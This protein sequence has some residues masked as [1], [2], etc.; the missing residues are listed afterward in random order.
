MKNKVILILILVVVVLVA[1]FGFMSIIELQEKYDD[2]IRTIS[3][4]VVAASWSDY[5]NTITLTDAHGGIFIFA[6]REARVYHLTL[7]SDYNVTYSVF[8]SPPMLK[9]MKLI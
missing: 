7:G 6:N 5:G 4:T 2:S 9:A 8:T 3:M 1:F